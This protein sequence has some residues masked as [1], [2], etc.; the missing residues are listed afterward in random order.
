MSDKI[1]GF[2]EVGVSEDGTEVVVNHPD[3]DPDKD[4]NGHIVFS[5][6]QARALAKLLWSKADEIEKGVRR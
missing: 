2:L 5:P 6:N 1:A 3:I 4:G